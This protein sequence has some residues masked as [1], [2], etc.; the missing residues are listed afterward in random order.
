MRECRMFFT[1]SSNNKDVCIQKKNEK[2]VLCMLQLYKGRTITEGQWVEVYK[3]LNNGLFSIRDNKTKLVLA[4]GH[5][6]LL[7]DVIE[8]VS[9]AGR[10]RVLKEQRKNVHA[11]LKGKI[12]FKKTQLSISMNKEISY[13]PYTTDY[14]YIKDKNKK[15][16]YIRFSSIKN[17]AVWVDKEKIYLI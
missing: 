2:G 3:N 6:F 7:T 10:N 12:S 16:E 8:R 9:I 5:S 1:I 15:D 17:A 11:Y 4:H 14:F 13:N